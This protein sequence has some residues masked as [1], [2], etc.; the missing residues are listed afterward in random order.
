MDEARRPDTPLHK[1]QEEL[2]M[3][4]PKVVQR[5][6]MIDDFIRNFFLKRGMTRSL[7]TFQREWYEKSQKGKIKTEDGDRIPD[8]KI[9]N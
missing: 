5:Q 6:E 2:N 8:I 1:S 7:E 3:P 9:M 4:G